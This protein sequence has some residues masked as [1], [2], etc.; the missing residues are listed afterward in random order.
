MGGTEVQMG[1]KTWQMVQKQIEKEKVALE[2]WETWSKSRNTW[3]H[4]DI[5]TLSI[6]KRISHDINIDNSH[7]FYA[8]QLYA[9][10]NQLVH[11][12]IGQFIK[13]RNWYALAEQLAEDL[14]DVPAIFEKKEQS[15][16]I[17]ILNRVKDHFF[18][19]IEKPSKLHNPLKPILSE[20]AI[21]RDQETAKKERNRQKAEMQ[22]LR[23]QAEEEAGVK[24][25]SVES[26]GEGI[27]QT[28]FDRYDSTVARHRR[29][30]R[31][32]TDASVIR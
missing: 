17:R 13:L 8:I 11:C 26:S 24:R 23:K 21:R 28:Y 7:A 5:P 32:W 6:I 22:R 19:S 18:I 2:K 12:M 27:H 15:F 10:R 3:D 31:D 4:P 20:K 29:C 25:T 16:M 1:G 9:K 14:R 30:H